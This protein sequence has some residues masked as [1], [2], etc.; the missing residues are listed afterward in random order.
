MSKR[1][2]KSIGDLLEQEGWKT[3]DTY[4]ANF[5][6]PISESAVYIFVKTDLDDAS[7][8]AVI[9]VGMSKNLAK[10]W[11]NHE[12]MSAASQGGAYIRRF[13]R[14]VQENELRETERAYIQKFDPPWNLAGRIKGLH[15]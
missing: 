6:E 11:T 8:D 2:V 12:V 3:P 4:G 9:Y 13:F 14:P 10:R 7:N 5:R 15:S 1:A